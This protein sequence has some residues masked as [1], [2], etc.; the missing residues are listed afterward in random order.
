VL[1]TVAGLRRNARTDVQRHR[2]AG[3]I[4]VVEWKRSNDMFAQVIMYHIEL[5]RRPRCAGPQNL[6]P[7][8]VVLRPSFANDASLAEAMAQ[9]LRPAINGSDPA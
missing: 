5:H 2:G 6:S 9:L 7:C 8:A 1:S 4:R 3:H